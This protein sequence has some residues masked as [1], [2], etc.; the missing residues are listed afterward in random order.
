MN[1]E[2]AKTGASHPA[3]IL[4]VDETPANLWFAWSTR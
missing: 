1:P 4:V 2:K 3:S